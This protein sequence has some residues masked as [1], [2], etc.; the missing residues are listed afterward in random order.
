MA[1]ELA[2]ALAGRLEGR[3]NV[4]ELVRYEVGP[5]VTAH[6]G[7]GTAGAVFFPADLTSG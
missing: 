4:E 2:A 7:L 6:T 5:S 3:P 1:P